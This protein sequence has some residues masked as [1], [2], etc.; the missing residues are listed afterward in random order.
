MTPAPPPHPLPYLPPVMNLRWTIPGLALEVVASLNSSFVAFYESCLKVSHGYK[1]CAKLG[2]RKPGK[3]RYPMNQ[4]S[5]PDTVLSGS[6]FQFIL[7]YGNLPAKL[8][9]G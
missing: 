6:F 9:K 2:Q 7:R 5:A 8:P 4:V 3:P 1:V